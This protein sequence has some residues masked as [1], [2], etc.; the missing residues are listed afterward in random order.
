MLGINKNY[1]I[2]SQLKVSHIFVYYIT[3][4]GWMNILQ[5]TDI[6]YYNNKYIPTFFLLV[7]PGSLSIHIYIYIMCIYIYIIIYSTKKNTNHFSKIFR[8]FA[9]F[10]YIYNIYIYIH[11]LYIYIYIYI[12]ICIYIYIYIYIF[13]T[14]TH[15]VTKLGQLIDIRKGNSFQY[16]LNNLEEWG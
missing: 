1:F 14:T 9:F 10:S 15:E 12:Y 13:W 6:Y 3:I 5:N 2:I 11:I 7:L 8:Q 4:I 16:L